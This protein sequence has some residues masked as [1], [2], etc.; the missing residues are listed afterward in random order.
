MVLKAR[1]LW[2]YVETD[3]GATVKE[4]VISVMLRLLARHG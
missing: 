2:K 3:A 4:K 1:K